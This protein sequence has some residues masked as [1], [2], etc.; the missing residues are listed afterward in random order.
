MTMVRVLPLLLRLCLANLSFINK[1]RDFAVCKAGQG[2]IE[3]VVDS[4]RYFVL[5]IEDEKT[6]KH[7]FLGIGF[8][9][10]SEAF[11]FNAAIA[12]H[13]KYVCSVSVFRARKN[14]S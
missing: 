9:E 8:R 2:A 5:K 10:R 4:S 13:S 11:D 7:A 6:G 14:N 3:P 1:G 12:D